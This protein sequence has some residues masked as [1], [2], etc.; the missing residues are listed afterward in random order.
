MAFHLSQLTP[1]PRKP[2]VVNTLAVET[3][4]TL[5]LLRGNLNDLGVNLERFGQVDYLLTSQIGAAVAFLECDGL[6]VPSARW[7]CEN[8]TLFPLN[9]KFE[10]RLEFVGARELDWIAWAEKH[11]LEWLQ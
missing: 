9:H 1:I 2:V 4:N 10:D 3:R 5:R 8:L 11:K 7:D 6:I